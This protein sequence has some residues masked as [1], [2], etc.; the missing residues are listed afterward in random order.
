MPPF[1]LLIAGFCVLTALGAVAWRAA[2]RRAVGAAVA[3]ERR[4]LA[5]VLHDDVA[6]DL[7]YICTRARH[8]AHRGAHKPDLLDL[9]DVAASALDG[10]RQAI[11]ALRRSD[12]VPFHELFDATALELEHREGARL[13]Y[14]IPTDFDPSAERGE[15]LLGIVREAVI[16]AARHASA[17]EV[18]VRLTRDPDVHLHIRDNGTGF[19]PHTP[20]GG[21]GLTGMRERAQVAG[22]VLELSSRPGAGTE[23]DVVLP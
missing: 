3:Q 16:N 6:Q 14:E 2:R 13:R 23:I 20:A 9:A 17:S 7:A 15:A 21:F 19:D 11:A 12:H 18:E 10:T 8:L 1:A 5:R 4:R 22:G